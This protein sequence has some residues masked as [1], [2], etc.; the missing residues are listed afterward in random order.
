MEI[1][2]EHTS[3]QDCIFAIYKE[4]R[5]TDCSFDYLLDHYR[6]NHDVV[7]AYNEKGDFYVINGRYCYYKRTKEWADR[8]KD[9][10]CLLEDI[11]AEEQKISYVSFILGNDY[12]S[13]ENLMNTINSVSSQECAPSMI[14]VI[15]PF[16][17]TIDPLEVNS[18]LNSVEIKWRNSVLQFGMEAVKY[19]DNFIEMH[20]KK[21]P[22]YQT[23]MAGKTIDEDLMAL[24]NVKII[25]DDFRFCRIDASSRF[26][27]SS[28]IIGNSTSHKLAPSPQDFLKETIKW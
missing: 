8:H 24:L 3:C 2:K 17:T 7:G 10:P 22:I 16:G 6:A 23:I 9:A 14:N 11:V 13:I 19:I 5:Q 28:L 18:I 21:Y 20:Y 1:K 15:L 4:N 25:E 26:G 12:G 27:E